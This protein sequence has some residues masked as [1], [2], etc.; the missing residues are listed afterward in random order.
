MIDSAYGDLCY[1]AENDTN[2]VL[3]FWKAGKCTPKGFLNG[4]MPPHPTFYAKSE[5]Y[6]KFGNFNIILRNSADYELMLRFL[7]K[8]YVSSSY[9]DDV[10]VMMRDGGASNNSIK[11]RLNANFED[12]K[13][14]RINNLHP[15]FYTGF[16]KPVRKI[17]QFYS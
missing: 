6:R 5:I 17:K 1:V 8:H 2:E 7:F 16:L 12:R 15:R 10:L 14:W 13:A 9:I 11:S 3:R 4:W